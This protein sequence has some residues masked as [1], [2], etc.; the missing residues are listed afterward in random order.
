MRWSRAIHH[1]EELTHVCPDMAR[2]PATIFPLRV[3]A[4]WTFGEVLTSRDDLDFLPVELARR[5]AH[6]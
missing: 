1:L 6:R 3:T 4:L 2:R 5:A